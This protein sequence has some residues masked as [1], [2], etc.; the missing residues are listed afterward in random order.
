MLRLKGATYTVIENCLTKI[1]FKQFYIKILF[2]IATYI[3]SY[4][5]LFG[6]KYSAKFETCRKITHIFV[7]FISNFLVFVTVHGMKTV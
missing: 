2:I 5:N 6:A 7:L 4:L 3:L 1:I